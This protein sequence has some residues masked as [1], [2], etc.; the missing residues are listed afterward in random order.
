MGG[1]AFGPVKVLCPNV[2][3]G[4]GS[5]SGWAGEKGKGGENGGFQ[6]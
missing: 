2:G 5:R 4:P 3:P 6:S 1:E